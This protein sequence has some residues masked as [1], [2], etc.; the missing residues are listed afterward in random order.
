MR[1]DRIR[2][3]HI[4][5]DSNPADADGFGSGLRRPAEARPMLFKERLDFSRCG[6]PPSVSGLVER[7]FRQAYFR[8]AAL[9]GRDRRGRRRR[10]TD[11]LEGA[12]REESALALGA[13]HRAA[14]RLY[15]SLA[16]IKIT[17]IRFLLL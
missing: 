14:S 7:H 12:D 4:P 15:L 17:L 6:G 16:R 5:Q 1:W 9:D 11:L 8:V 2:R 13:A 10:Q 3:D